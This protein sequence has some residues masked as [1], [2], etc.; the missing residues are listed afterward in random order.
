MATQQRKYAAGPNSRTITALC[1]RTSLVVMTPLIDISAPGIAV[2]EAGLCDL[3]ASDR[4]PVSLLSRRQLG[5]F[6]SVRR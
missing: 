4:S 1:R 5:A 2:L 6:W 3:R